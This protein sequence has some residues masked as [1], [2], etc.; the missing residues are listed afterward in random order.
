MAPNMFSN[1]RFHGGSNHLLVP[2]GILHDVFGDTSFGVVRVLTTTSTFIG[3]QYPAEVT[4]SFTAET[5]RLLK[6][7]GHSGRQWNPM[8]GRVIALKAVGGRPW[9]RCGRFQLCT[10]CLQASSN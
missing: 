6:K 9:T 3:N 5:R 8:L 10:H 4:S 2:T 1:Q 7:A